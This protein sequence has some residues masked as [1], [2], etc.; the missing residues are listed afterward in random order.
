M[1]GRIREA[2]GGEEAGE[3]MNN[4]AQVVE[5]VR[6]ATV[7]Q[8][9]QYQLMRQAFSTVTSADI[10]AMVERITADPQTGTPGTRKEPIDGAAYF[11]AHYCLTARRLKIETEALTDET[12]PL[13]F[14]LALA[15]ADYINALTLLSRGGFVA[16]EQL[17]EQ[18]PRIAAMAGGKKS[19]K[20]FAEPRKWVQSEWAQHQHEYESKADFARIYAPLALQKFN[21]NV[22]ERTI[23]EDWLSS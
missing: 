12:I 11:F 18:A 21:V 14:Q 8:A 19:R 4:V 16:E 13:V 23:R 22:T 3:I 15:C 2:R 20:K 6:A 1:V 5:I 10:E 7:R 17:Q 9:G